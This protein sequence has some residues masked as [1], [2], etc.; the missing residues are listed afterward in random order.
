MPA[1]ARARRVET[2]THRGIV[3]TWAPEARVVSFTYD[4]DRALTG[5]AADVIIPVVARWVGDERPYGIL[6]DASR[7]LEANEAW[8]RRWTA[9]HRSHARLV[10]IAIF[11]ASPFIQGFLHLYSAWSGVALRCFP[12]EHA[13]RQWLGE[14]HATPPG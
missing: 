7:T 8:R 4:D 12:N 6:V 9:F 2:F 10:R 11:K 14:A 3:V 13:A 5:E 1:R